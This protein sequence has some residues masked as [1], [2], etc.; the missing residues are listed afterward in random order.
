M[1]DGTTSRTALFTKESGA[2]LKPSDVDIPSELRRDLETPEDYRRLFS[3]YEATVLKRETDALDRVTGM[4]EEMAGAL[5]CME[6]G[7]EYC[8]RT[9]IA[10]AIAKTT[11]MRVKDVRPAA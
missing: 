5:V 3:E 7:P 11:G 8:H 10:R 4:L 9:R 6:A 2:P 1:R